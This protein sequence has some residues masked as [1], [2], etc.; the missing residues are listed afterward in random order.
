MSKGTHTRTI[1]TV[2]IEIVDTQPYGPEWTAGQIMDRARTGALKTIA[3]LN[4]S[5]LCVVGTPKIKM[6]I[7]EEGGDE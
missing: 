1:A 7:T 6:V 4:R 2:Q 5:D 3:E